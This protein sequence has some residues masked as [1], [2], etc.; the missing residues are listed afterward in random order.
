MNYL[1]KTQLQKKKGAYLETI[2]PHW[3][4]LLNNQ[5]LGPTW[6]IL[7]SVGLGKVSEKSTD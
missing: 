6:R 1:V 2:L 4:W 7:A 3:D 5:W